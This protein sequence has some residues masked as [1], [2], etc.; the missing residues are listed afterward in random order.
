MGGPTVKNQK[1]GGGKF[2]VKITLAL[3]GIYEKAIALI[4]SLWAG[5]KAFMS[6]LMVSMGD[7][8]D[9]NARQY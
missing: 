8:K 1:K 3:G 9:Q 6:Y 4:L 2:Q 7:G 5:D